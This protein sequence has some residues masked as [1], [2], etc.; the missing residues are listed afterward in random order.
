MV[1]VDLKRLFSGRDLQHLGTLLELVLRVQFTVAADALPP[2]AV[3]GVEPASSPEVV[4]PSE[5]ETASTVFQLEASNCRN[6]ESRSSIRPCA[7]T[8]ARIGVPSE[9]S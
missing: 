7:G 1:V 4:Q 9:P 8:C 6:F 3:D 5:S 2:Y